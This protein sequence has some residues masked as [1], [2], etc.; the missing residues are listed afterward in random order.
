MEFKEFGKQNEKIALLIHGGWVS[1]RTLKVQIEE[2]KKNYHVIVP[3]LDGHNI[4]DN[5]ELE[6]IELE[7]ARIIEYFTKQDIF[8]ID[9]IYGAS[10]GADIALEIMCQSNNFVKYAFIESGSLG[11][12]KFAAWFLINI[13]ETAMYHGVRE[14]F[15]WK[16]FLDRF[17]IKIK[18]P[19]SLYSDTRNLIKHMSRKT[20]RN[21]Q[22][23]VC[24]YYLK[25][26]IR[27]I[28][29]H[30]LIVYSSKEKYLKKPYDQM[31]AMVS[32]MHIVCLEGYNHGQLCIGEPNKQL[33]MLKDFIMRET[34][35]G[36]Q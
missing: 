18:M 28:D 29:T 23:L 35:K 2:L 12:N 15:F 33:S 19:H 25:E 27:N 8:N 13:S 11:I 22:K 36:I 7:A 9:I 14:H 6:S 34:Y 5:S 26:S 1:W 10:L 32:N 30:C 17:L 3:V 24:N 31:K 20:I 21:V 4:H 16:K